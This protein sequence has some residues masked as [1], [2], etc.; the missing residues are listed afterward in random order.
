M[1]AINPTQNRT[2]CEVV[3]RNPICCC[4][5][6]LSTCL[7]ILM[8]RSGTR[9]D[10]C[11]LQF[12]SRVGQHRVTKLYGLC[13]NNRTFSFIYIELHDEPQNVQEEPRLLPYARLLLGCKA[14]TS[15]GSYAYKDGLVQLYRFCDP[16]AITHDAIVLGVSQW[17]FFLSSLG[18]AIIFSVFG[19]LLRLERGRR[20]N[21]TGTW[22]MKR[23]P[24]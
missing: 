6:V 2:F 17:F 12:R 23:V 10:T 7:A 8:F 22:R 15:V 20:E 5:L 14:D 11:Y 13:S 19:L 18:S 4:C 1:M 3:G 24:S 9:A 16:G 21:E